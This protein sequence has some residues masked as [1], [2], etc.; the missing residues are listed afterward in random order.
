MNAD[1]GQGV[2]LPRSSSP[3]NPGER[4]TF[5]A[6]LEFESQQE[7]SGWDPCLGIRSG[8]RALASTAA[9]TASLLS[10]GGWACASVGSST[11]PWTSSGTDHTRRSLAEGFRSSQRFLP[12]LRRPFRAGRASTLGTNHELIHA[13]A[14]SPR[15]A[16]RRPSTSSS[17]PWSD[18]GRS[19]ERG[20]HIRLILDPKTFLAA[21]PWWSPWS[22][23][24]RFAIDNH[25]DQG[26][27]RRG[28]SA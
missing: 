27:A 22:V 26:G 5:V 16:R 1:W 24:V 9:A 6:D 20:W 10:V 28:H 3:P 17:C 19:P 12:I 4:H 2:N 21:R 14:K 13:C 18:R 15:W 8:W 7:E 11:L 23:I 25:V